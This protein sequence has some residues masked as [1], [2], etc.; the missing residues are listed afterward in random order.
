MIDILLATYNGERYIK[1]QIES[2]LNQTY[3]D[4]HIIVRDDGSTDNTQAILDG[5]ASSYPEKFVVINDGISAG[6][7]AANFFEL[8]KHS[9]A[10]YIMFCD[11]DDVWKKD[12]VQYSLDLLKKAEE[13]YGEDTPLLAYTDYHT[14]DENLNSTNENKKGNIVYRHNDRLN[15]LL[16]QNYITGCTIIINKKLLNIASVQY[17]PE[18]LMHD[19]WLALCASAFG[20][21][22][23][24]NKETML[25]RQHSDQSVG[26]ID[27][28]SPK[29]IF[30]K[31]INPETKKQDH[32]CE[33][34]AQL[35]LRCY[36]DKLSDENQKCI[37]RFATIRKEPKKLKRISI[38][39]R[40]HYLKSTFVRRLGQIIYL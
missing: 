2:L 33:V 28:S 14:V 5:Y 15:Y 4:F 34:Q 9:Q 30:S 17:Q 10:D 11:Q 3:Q 39:F 22:V 35:F 20:R 8:M 19:W 37:Y 16:I 23:Y 6:G 29:Y 25:Y 38:L 32:K 36:G 12:K 40:G 1:E 24:S 21:I 26:R 18:I 27:V 31:L 13:E 7:A